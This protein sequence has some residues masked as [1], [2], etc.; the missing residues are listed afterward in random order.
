MFPVRACPLRYPSHLCGPSV[1]ERP[2]PVPRPPGVFAWYLVDVPPG[3]PTAANKTPQDCRE[4]AATVIYP[5]SGRI[6]VMSKQSSGCLALLGLGR[7]VNCGNP[8]KIDGIIAVAHAPLFARS[9]YPALAVI[10]GGGTNPDHSVKIRTEGL[11]TIVSWAVN[12]KFG[13]IVRG[14]RRPT[15]SD[16]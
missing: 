13:C 11:D 2:S 3:V 7:G 5:I 12:S 9:D 6:P 15:R 1:L 4:I 10:S 14:G 8:S 16:R